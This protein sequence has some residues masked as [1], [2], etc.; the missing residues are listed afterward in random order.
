[1]SP[2]SLWINSTDSG[3]QHR[4]RKTIVVNS[5]L[6]ITGFSI[7]FITFGASASLI[8]QIL[9]NYQ[10]LIR[11]VGGVF[12]ILFGLFLM[13]ACEAQVSDGREAHSPA[14]SPGRL[15]RFITDRRHLCRRLAPCVGPVLG[16]MLLYAGTT[17][18]LMDGVTL[19]AFYSFGLGFPLF[20]AAMGVNRFL[21]SF[22]QVRAYLQVIS[23][24]SGVALVVFGVLIYSDRLANLTSIFERY[25][26]GSYLGTD[27]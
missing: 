19:L 26:I 27:G 17:E 18:T 14:Q 4:L 3:E 9:T 8:G 6:F 7:V 11:K 5:L 23:V 22:K 20:M 2:V 16:T 24:S 13:G 21:A 1:M 12:I 25:G 10:N 15:C